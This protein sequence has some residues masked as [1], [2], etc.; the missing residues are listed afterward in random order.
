MIIKHYADVEPG[1]YAGVPEG[2][3]VREM[4]TDRDGAPRFALR[5]FDVEPGASTLSIPMNG[6]MKCLFSREKG[7]SEVKGKKR[8]LQKGTPLYRSQ[9]SPLLH[10]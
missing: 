3:Q 7:K 5:V 1:T 9:R 2:V 6:S 4:I 10:G 8:L